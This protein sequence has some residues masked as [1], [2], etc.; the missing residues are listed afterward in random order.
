MAI[1]NNEVLMEDGEVLPFADLPVLLRTQPSSILVA[2]HFGAIIKYLDTEF[3]G[4]PLFQFRASPVERSSW[5]PGRKLTA[6]MRD[7]IIG[8]VGFKGENKKKGHYHYPLSPYTFCLKTVNELRRGIPDEKAT[9]VKL[10]EWAK[11]VRDFLQ[12]NELNLSPTSGGIAAQLLKD[13]RFY[14]EP[15]R[16][17]PRHTNSKAREEL[18]G[19]FYKLYAAVEGRG[20][21]NAAYLDQT[22][23]HHTAARDLKFP[24]A[25]TLY[26]RGRYN[27]LED[28]SFAK[29]GTERY[30]KLIAEHGLFYL[31]Y[32]AP[33]FFPT[34][35]PLPECDRV[36]SG[37]GRGYF[38]SNE[39][40]YLKTLGVRI[41]HI[42]ACW[43]SPDT[44][45]GLNRYAE[46]ALRE[47][48]SSPFNSKK[49]LKP[50]LL[51]T[52]GV[53]ASK[54]KKMEFGYKQAKGG[55]PKKYPCG[56][57]FLD[58]Q[59]KVSEKLR[60][61]AMSNVI[62]RGMV[63]A[64][65]RLTSLEFAREL[66]KQGHT[67]LAVYADSIFV[68]DGLPLPLLP[69]PWRV[70]DFLTALKFE[71]STH[72]TSLELSK[73]PGIPAHLRARAKLPARPKRK[74]KA[75]T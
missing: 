3:E 65:T 74:A 58:V 34:D 23:A 64:Q 70:Q 57:G 39:L 42:I 16:K 48:D 4:N 15:R 32:E 71:S 28:R 46:W 75:T 11:E 26:R 14:P 18:P 52:Y 13:K 44:D 61:P 38:Y 60:E 21:H 55:K 62:H 69:K 19:N 53:L 6:T 25:N 54:P 50:T 56:S 36:K 68:E 24:N 12:K 72:F 20:M 45:P 22:S 31:A 35:F 59:V 27:T 29:A 2:H 51:S 5:A 8:Y 17:V 66:A 10:M 49:W 63:E 47:I 73:T 30:K 9:L 41:R 33:K 37:Y 40:P 43:T 1:D 67:I 7:C